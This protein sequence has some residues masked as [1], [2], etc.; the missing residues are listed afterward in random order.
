M[1]VNDESKHIESEL[2]ALRDEIRAPLNEWDL[3]KWSSDCL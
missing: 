3:I 1:A 2:N